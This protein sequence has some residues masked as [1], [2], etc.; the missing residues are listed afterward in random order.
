MNGIDDINDEDYTYSRPAATAV[1]RAAAEPC[2]QC[3]N[4][5][6]LVAINN[7]ALAMANAE[8]AR[9][10]AKLDAVPVQEIRAVVG[11][12][13]TPIGYK[14]ERN[15]IAEWLNSPAVQP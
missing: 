12:S 10:Q 8:I 2:Q 3:A 4:W 13:V 6:E 15:V 11:A 9:L 1:A 7:E 5:R 14:A